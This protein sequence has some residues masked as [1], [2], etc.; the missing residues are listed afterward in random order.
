MAKFLRLRGGRLYSK[1]FYISSFGLGLLLILYIFEAIFHLFASPLEP[2]TK[3]EPIDVVYT[4][5][6][7]SDPV[8]LS[9]LKK[10]LRS[11]NISVDEKYLSQRFID[12][13]ELLFSLRSLEKFAPWI[14]HVYIVTNGQIPYWLNLDCD[15]LTLVT[16]QEIFLDKSDLPTF[17]SP[18]IESHLHRI[19]GL[20]RRFLYFNDDVFLGQ[21]IFMEDFISQ[22]EGFKLYF[23]YSL[24]MC[25]PQCFWAYVAD[26]Q[27]DTACNNFYCQY[28][29]GDC[30]NANDEKEDNTS[31]TSKHYRNDEVENEKNVSKF[32][33]SRE[34]N[35]T[36]KN[37]SEVVKEYNNK[38]M[39]NEKIKKK[40]YRKR[41]RKLRIMKGIRNN[42]TTYSFVNRTMF[43]YGDSLQYSNRLFNL[44]YGFLPRFVPSHA[45]VL[46]D[47]DLITN[48]QRKFF[49]EV[50]VT[51][52]NR[53]RNHD[54]L[55][56]TFSYYYFIYH[57]RVKFDAGEVFD[58]FDTDKSGTWSDREIRTL[59]TRIYQ[60]P[61]SYAIVEHFELMLLNCSQNAVFK[62][63]KTP[64]YERYL[65]SH[66]PVIS[67]EMILECP[68]LLKMLELSFG[69][70]KK[71]KYKIVRNSEGQYIHFKQLNSNVTDVVGQLDE[72][73]SEPRKFVCLND[74]LDY[75]K[76][77]ENEFVNS[78]LQDFYLSLFPLPSTY[79]LP[80]EYRN[81]FLHVQDL[82]EWKN[83]HF[84]I[85]VVVYLGAL[86]VF[87][88]IGF[89]SCIRK[90]CVI[91]NR[92]F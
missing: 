7:G 42:S 66:L 63:V 13:N 83:H 92:F 86:F 38:M 55:Q 53:F 75:A 4:W 29:G 59:L 51:S 1:L 36:K 37:F 17:S 85:K 18:A 27:C 81:K 58:M 52:R 82:E 90:I 31:L 15:K 8:F 21:S 54:D 11:R 89:K 41:Q 23:S 20:S 91:I 47:K 87:Y 70:K 22:N 69:N 68:E 80:K 44:K 9:E 49:K 25:A 34:F 43:A 40:R 72:I 24:G 14:N 26:D 39:E 2:C 33:L 65:D 61:L 84:R 35:R 50:L 10:F 30:E 74:N 45:P 71:Y 6:N 28:D 79:E 77:S 56:F 46:V 16:H 67:K 3:N 76:G 57:E 19:P 48:F 73:R 62:E 32:K 12:K 88:M 5:V 64:K 78:L 60:L